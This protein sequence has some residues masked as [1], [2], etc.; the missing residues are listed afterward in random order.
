MLRTYKLKH[1][2]NQGKQKKI[3]NLLEEYR[4]VSAKISNRQWRYFYENGR[5]NR[6]LE[7]NSIKSKLSQRYRQTAQY[8]VVAQ[9]E[10]YLGNRQNDFKAYLKNSNFDKE[11]KI[12]L[13]YINRYKKWFHQSVKMQ[14]NEIEQNIIKLSRIIIRNILKKNRK[15]NLK[16]CNMALDAKVMEITPNGVKK[17]KKSEKLK[18]ENGEFILNKSGNPKLKT[19]IEEQERKKSSYDYWIKLSTLEKGQK[20]YLPITTNDYFQGIKGDVSNFIQINFQ[21]DIDKIDGNISISNSN[22]LNY[23]KYKIS[24]CLIK[25]IKKEKYLPKI[26]KLAL[27]LGLNNLFAT[28]IGE[29]YGRNFSKLLKKYDEIVSLLAKNRQ[30]QKLKTLSKKYKKLIN[31]IKA[32]L[33]NEINRVI[34]NLI[35]N[36]RPKEIVVERLNFTSPKL[37]KKLNRMLSNF[38]KNI[39]EK[40]FESIK[41]RYGIEITQINPAYTSQE[42]SKC[43]YVEKKNRKSQAKF[44]CGFCGKKQNADINSSKNILARSSSSLKDIFTKRAFILDK[45]VKNFIERHL[46]VL[47]YIFKDRDLG[48]SSGY[49]LSKIKYKNNLCYNSLANT[50]T[51]NPY[52]TNYLNGNFLETHEVSR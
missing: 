30:K 7:V 43:G 28:N 34:N 51:S 49:T 3:L 35:K 44:I 8:Q 37:S 21:Q 6:D 32:Y 41:E 9:L 18:D 38:G 50:L 23:N 42:C 4:K 40:K 31:K 11:T 36:N 10:S 17:V 24:V 16:F 27:D 22:S 45:T 52:L 12:K 2:I 14:N 46:V 19:H 47:L 29:L 25:N 15:P 26:N 20:I 1:S 33:K 48:K 13:Y 39:I 5:F